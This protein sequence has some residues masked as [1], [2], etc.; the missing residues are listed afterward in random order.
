VTAFRIGVRVTGVSAKN[1]AGEL[2]LTPL[3]S[4]RGMVTGIGEENVI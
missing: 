4:D 3:V 1:A 2:F